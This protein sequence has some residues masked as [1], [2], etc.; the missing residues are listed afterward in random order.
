MKT[1]ISTYFSLDFQTNVKKRIDVSKITNFSKKDTFFCN[2]HIL[3]EFLDKLLMVQ[4]VLPGKYK[5]YSKY[6]IIAHLQHLE[7][8]RLLQDFFWQ[9][10][11]SYLLLDPTRPELWFFYYWRRLQVLTN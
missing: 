6:E 4:L 8:R 5:N 1:Q 7:K 10:K 11:K 3:T 2:F 9:I